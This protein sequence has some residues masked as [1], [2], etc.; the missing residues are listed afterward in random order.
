TVVQLSSVPETALSARVRTASWAAHG[1]A[2]GSGFMAQLMA[3]ELPAES[4][5]QLVAQLW[6]LYEAIEAEAAGV[7]DPV[8]DRVAIPEVARATSL[9]ADAAHWFGPDW[10]EVVSPLP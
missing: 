3:G 1:D 5:A 7:T 8:L 9:A 2:E 10:R 4:F 6:F